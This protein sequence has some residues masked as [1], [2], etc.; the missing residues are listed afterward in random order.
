MLAVNPGI[1]GQKCQS[2][3]LGKV[4][5][6]RE[7]YPQLPY[8]LVDGGIDDTTAPLAAAA[9]ANAL[10]SGSYLFS[11]PRGGMAQRVSLLETALLEY[12]Q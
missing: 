3:V 4:R 12:G 6:L 8:L 10:V 7:R 2:A 1:G 11:A 9:G 5:A